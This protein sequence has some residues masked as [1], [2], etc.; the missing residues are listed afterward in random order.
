MSSWRVSQPSS[1][2]HFQLTEACPSRATTP[3]RNHNFTKPPCDL[4]SS[5]TSVAEYLSR[6]SSTRRLPR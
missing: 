6:L 1:G 4:S 5:A 3:G 2:C